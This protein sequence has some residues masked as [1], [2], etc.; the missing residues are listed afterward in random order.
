ME[1]NLRAEVKE[2]RVAGSSNATDVAH[3]A[4]RFLEEGYDVYLLAIGN[5][6]V[7]NAA[8]ATVASRKFAASEGR[9]ICFTSGYKKVIIDGAEK[10]VLRLRLRYTFGC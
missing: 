1:D 6:A 10:S 2:L 4:V 7:N 3:A 9:D 5:V 8:R